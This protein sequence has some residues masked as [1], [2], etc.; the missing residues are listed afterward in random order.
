[1]LR[2]DPVEAAGSRPAA[3][4]ARPSQSLALSA[5]SPGASLTASERV[6]FDA[7]Y[8]QHHGEVV[9]LLNRRLGNPDDAAELAQEAYLRILRYR[10]CDSDS[11]RHL[12]I[13][14][15]LNL[16]ASHGVRAPNR[17]RQVS[18]EEIEISLEAFSLDEALD[19]ER[20]LHRLM[21]VVTDLPARCRQIFLLRLIHGLRQRDIAE[22]CGI[23]TRRVEQQLAR[24][25]VLIRERMGIEDGAEQ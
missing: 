7:L 18:L 19:R 21:A 24:A 1:M 25:Q 4:S 20:R 10:H 3:S 16:A 8:R 22:R 15:V 23:S 13:R 14:T 11:L 12:L 2:V 9:R 17:C 6:R 5:V